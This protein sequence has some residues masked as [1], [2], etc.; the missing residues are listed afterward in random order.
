[1][2]A[3]K[4]ARQVNVLF[5]GENSHV[6]FGACVCAGGRSIA[7]LLIFSGARPLSKL[8]A[9]FPEAVVAMQPNGFI[10]NDIWVA[11]LDH[12]I[13]EWAATAR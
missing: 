12:F 2:L 9:G 1:M 8:F 10:T 3:R 5:E 7:P 6:T 4:G 13:K 11:W